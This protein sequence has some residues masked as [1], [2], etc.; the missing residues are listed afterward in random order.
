MDRIEQ[1]RSDLKAELLGV[2]TV[3]AGYRTTIAD[4]Q[5]TL[6]DMNSLGALVNVDTGEALPVVSI[7]LGDEGLTPK[8][9]QRLFWNSDLEVVLL[10]YCRQGHQELVIHDL[11]RVIGSISTKYVSTADHRWF[12]N[13][14]PSEFRV[15]R[16]MESREEKIWCSIGLNVRILGQNNTF[17]N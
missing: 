2:V 9:T 11:K 10:V 14:T 7:I 1:M 3:A 16:D 17:V 8:D 13:G 15:T 6:L 4:V 12:L 5:F